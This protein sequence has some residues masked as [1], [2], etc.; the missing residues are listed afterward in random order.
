MHARYNI[1]H[2]DVETGS[3]YKLGG[4]QGRYLILTATPGFSRMPRRT[5]EIY[6][7]RAYFD[8]G[9]CAIRTGVIENLGVAVGIASLPSS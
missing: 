3:T 2:G 4:E 8:V 5:V 7:T 1:Q 9:Q 6:T